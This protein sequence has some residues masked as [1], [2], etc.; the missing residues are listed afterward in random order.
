MSGAAIAAKPSPDAPHDPPAK[1]GSG[2]HSFHIFEKDTA[3]E[4]R[5][6]S[7]L[8]P[9]PGMGDRTDMSGAAVAARPFPDTSHDSIAK[10]GSGHHTFHLFEKDTAAEARGNSASSALPGSGDRT[11]AFGAWNATFMNVF[12]DIQHKEHDPSHHSR[13]PEEENT[14]EAREHS[15]ST[16]LPGSEDRTDRR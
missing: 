14:V 9:L 16:G 10:H 1:H 3:A 4:A 6:H 12:P 13:I 11:D 8:A 2:H 5:G 7:T 15:A